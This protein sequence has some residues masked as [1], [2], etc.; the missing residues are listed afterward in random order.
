MSQPDQEKTSTEFTFWRNH[1]HHSCFLAFYFYTNNYMCYIY[2]SNIYLITFCYIKL[3]LT[4]YV[5]TQDKWSIDTSIQPT[6]T[7]H[8]KQKTHN[9]HSIHCKW[10]H[11]QPD[12]GKTS[13]EST[14]WRNHNHHSSF[15]V[16]NQMKERH[17]QNS[18]F[19]A[20]I[21]TIL[22]TKTTK[23]CS[24]EHLHVACCILI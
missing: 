3:Y 7:W 17:Q 8:F 9:I 6:N 10:V 23:F 14:F 24:E 11:S 22:N 1:N 12:Q 13:T 5:G 15:L 18:H 19:A 21:T 2:A 4:M 16:H 20:T